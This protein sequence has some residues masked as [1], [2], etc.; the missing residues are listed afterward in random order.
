MTDKVQQLF[1]PGRENVMRE[2]NGGEVKL[3]SGGLGD[4]VPH[5]NRDKAKWGNNGFGNGADH[6]DTAPGR[7]GSNPGGPGRFDVGQGGG[8]GDSLGDDHGPR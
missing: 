5:D 3:V 2:L 6:N 4:P 7:S 1:G 8:K